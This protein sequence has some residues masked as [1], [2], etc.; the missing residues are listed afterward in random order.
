MR[1]EVGLGGVGEGAAQHGQGGRPAAEEG[2]GG[3]SGGYWVSEEVGLEGERRG[4]RGR[5]GT[6]KEGGLQQKGEGADPLDDI[7]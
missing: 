7:G 2:G 5:P 6:D 3:P 1:G 4:A